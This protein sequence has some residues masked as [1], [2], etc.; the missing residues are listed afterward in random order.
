MKSRLRL[1]QLVFGV[2]VLLYV[3][4]VSAQTL[5]QGNTGLAS[6]YPGDVGIASDPAVIFA[7]DFESYS[8]FSGLTG[9]GRWNQV[10]QSANTR[11]ATEAGN[12]FS[13]NKALEFW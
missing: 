9:T 6:R 2:L 10:Y 13:E 7:D 8:S 1:R 11:L 4:L 5:P 12:Y 3:A